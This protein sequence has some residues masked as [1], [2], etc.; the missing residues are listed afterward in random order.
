MTKDPKIE[1]IK[2]VDVKGIPIPIDETAGAVQPDGS[3]SRSPYRDRTYINAD[4]TVI[5]GGDHYD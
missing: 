5:W 2:I 4:G 1:E 3:I